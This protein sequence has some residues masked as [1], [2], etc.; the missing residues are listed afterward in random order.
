VNTREREV[1]AVGDDGAG[2][3]WSLEGGGGRATV[4]ARVLFTRTG[5]RRRVD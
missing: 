1:E 4:P 5:R 3:P 2:A